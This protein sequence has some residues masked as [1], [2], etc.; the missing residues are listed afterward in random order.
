LG[1]FDFLGPL[2]SF[3]VFPALVGVLET[4]GILLGSWLTLGDSLGSSEGE[5]EGKADD[6][7]FVLGAVLKVG[8]L[9]EGAREGNAEGKTEGEV[10][11]FELGTDDGET[12]GVK[13]GWSEGKKVDRKG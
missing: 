13:D 4:D 6:I 8:K 5:H 10:V 7:L 11:G 9:A 1:S 2:L 12:L 3:L